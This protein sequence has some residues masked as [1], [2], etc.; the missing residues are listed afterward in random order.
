[1]NKNEVPDPTDPRWVFDDGEPYFIDAGI[2]GESAPK[3]TIE[4]DPNPPK[5]Q[6]FFSDKVLGFA[7]EVIQ[8]VM[9]E[10]EGGFWR[11]TFEEMTDPE[12]AAFFI[13]LADAFSDSTE[14]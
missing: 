6:P 11:L 14:E 9:N 2:A 10:L 1:M 8:Y 4:N 3:V 12:K 5:I 13:S 7:D